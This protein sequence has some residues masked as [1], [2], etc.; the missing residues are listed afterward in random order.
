M[1]TK[2][3]QNI[4]EQIDAIDLQLQNLIT[5]RATLAVEIGKIKAQNTD[6]V[7]FYRPERE[8]QILQK[9]VERNAG[10]LSADQIT[11]IF[12]SILTACLNLQQP[13]RVATLGPEGT[14]SQLAA[15]K[16]FGIA[17]PLSLTATIAD[18]FQEIETQK[19]D[20]GVVPIENSTTGIIQPVLDILRTS[21]LITCGEILLPIHHCLLAKNKNLE[22]IQK[23]YAHEQAFLQCQQ[24]LAKHLPKI[25]CVAVNSNAEAARRAELEENTAAIASEQTAAMYHLAILEK[26]IEDNPN[27]VTRFLIIGSNPKAQL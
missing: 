10:P 8:A 16:H 23:I 9:I 2:N 3:L 21:A 27:N 11:L 7:T 15:I 18:V 5:K 14:F 25:Q 12:R 17:T 24:W 26:N 6:T 13:I 22:N 20:Y 19:A 1:N 4:R